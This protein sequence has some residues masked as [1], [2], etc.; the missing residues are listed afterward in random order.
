MNIEQNNSGMELPRGHILGVILLW[1]A[2]LPSLVFAQTFRSATY[3]VTIT[4]VPRPSAPADLHITDIRF[5]DAKGNR[6]DLLDA[7]ETIE[8]HFTLENKGKGHAYR[9]RLS[10]QNAFSTPGLQ[11]EGL[12]DLGELKAGESK[13]V[14]LQV[15]G[16]R[17]LPTGQS[18][19]NLSVLE[20]N[21]FHSEPTLIQF[22]TA[23]FRN[24]QLTIA[25]VV[26]TNNEGEGK[27]TLG[28]EVTMDVLIQNKGQGLARSVRVRMTCPAQVY[29]SGASEFAIGDLAP[30]ESRRVSF[31]FFA[32]KLYVGN[33][34]AIE[35][36]AI[37]ALGQYGFKETQ[38]VSLEKSLGKTTVVIEAQEIKNVEI[39]D[40]ALRSDVDRNI[41]ATDRTFPNRYALVIGNE[42]YSKF[43]RGLATESNVAFARNDAMVVRDYLQRTLGVP[44]AQIDLKLDAT[45]GEM[46][47]A[48]DR[49]NKLIKNMGGDA[50]VFVYYAGHGLPDEAGESFL[51]PV[52]VSGG[53]VRMGVRLADWY[54]KL[55]EFP[56]KRVTVFLDACFSGGARGTSLLAMSRGVKI[57]PRS[58][59]LPGK[60]LVFTATSGEESALPWVAQGH[61]MFTYH[62]LKFWQENL[63]EG[64]YGELA[65][66]LRRQV[67]LESVRTNNKEQT[68]QVLYSDGVEEE[69]RYWIFR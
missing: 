32:N 44:A 54:Q 68:P 58:N 36:Q 59:Q 14:V 63:A 38:R 62:L 41:P 21:G 53:N 31:G 15:K 9:N 17:N 43:Q 50:E 29:A 16:G 1:V 18:Q 12:L 67:G 8:I 3:P 4:E 7:D 65:E 69:W 64:T 27:I 10:T 23:A 28:K 34:I 35:V 48:M 33:E 37:E 49:L 24:P 66:R 47:Q 39:T 40:Q 11:F 55:T 57:V 52:D 6:N 2:T 30:N 46:V 61:G 20:A 45:T 19:L 51:I 26:F 60:L 56:S 5:S 22:N 13:S 42:D 25:D